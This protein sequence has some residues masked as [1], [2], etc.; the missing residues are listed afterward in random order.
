MAP[1]G[2]LRQDGS[3]RISCVYPHVLDGALL[4]G[5]MWRSRKAVDLLRDPRLV[6]RNAICTNRGDEVEVILRGEAKE[7]GDAD[8]RTRYLEAVPAW[9]DRRFHLFAVDLEDAALISYESGEQYVR[10]W[11]AGTERRRRY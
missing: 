6:L 3:P 7:V 4:L 11:P 2:T 10:V 9:G 5:M 8:T 1:V